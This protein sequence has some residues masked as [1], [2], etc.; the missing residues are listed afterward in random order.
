MRGS[1]VASDA[2]YQR[3]CAWSG[4]VCVSL[5]FGA[6]ISAGWVP[7]MDPSWSA[8][9]VAAFY[10]KHTAGIRVGGVL[11]F[12]SGAFYAVYTAVISSQMARIR[13]VSRTAVYAQLAGGAFGCLT[14]M[15]PAMLFL[16]TAYRPDRLVT[17]TQLLN[18]MSWIL[19]VMAWPPFAAQQFSFAYAILADRNPERVFPR[20][21]GFL[22]IWV[23]M[24]FIPASFLSFFYDGPFAWNGV[25]GI[26]IPAVVFCIQFAANVAM[27]LRAINSEFSDT[28]PIPVAS[29]VTLGKEPAYSGTHG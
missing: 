18:D 14:F 2:G 13:D 24:G 27:L 5:F 22:N 6:F 19:L 8:E 28:E 15:V 9:H 10:Q 23:V 7:P 29:S 26:W 17:E 11:M 4:V 16:V 3:V 21:L 1:E 12:L 20:W 25:V